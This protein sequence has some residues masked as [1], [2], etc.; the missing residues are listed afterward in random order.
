MV[1]R[2]VD[3]NDAMIVRKELAI[4][5]EKHQALEDSKETMCALCHVV[6]SSVSLRMHFK[7]E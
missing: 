2:L 1:L 5:Q 6:D 7:K 3:E 4:A